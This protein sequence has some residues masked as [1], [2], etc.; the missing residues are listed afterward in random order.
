MYKVKLCVWLE[1]F[2]ASATIRINHSRSV[3]ADQSELEL[4]ELQLAIESEICGMTRDKLIEL[5]EHLEVATEGLGKLQMSKRIRETVEANVETSEDKMAFLQELKKVVCSEPPPP[6]PL[7]ISEDDGE[8]S[9]S[10]NANVEN[11]GPNVENPGPNVENPVQSKS[12][13]TETKV[14]VDLAKVFKRDFKIFG[15]I[16]GD[17]HKDSL[18]FVSLTRQ[19]DTGVKSGYK[20]TEVIE[21]VIRAVSP[22]LKL[23]SYLE[24][25]SELTL[26]RLKQILRAHFKE[27]SATELYQELAQLCQGTKESAQDF[28]IRAMNL[29]QQ[30]IFSS[31]SDSAVKYDPSLV[32]SLFIHVVETGLA[33]E[34]VRAKLRPLLEKSNV[35]DEELM[36]RVNRAVSAET[37][38]QNKMGGFIK[39]STLVN[40]VHNDP[41]PA[42]DNQ[43]I[44]GKKKPGANSDKECKQ[45]NLVAALEAV[46]ADLAS[47]KEAFNKSQASS[48]EQPRENQQV[49]NKGKSVSCKACQESGETNCSHCF[50]CGSTEH[51]ARG[52]KK[53]QGNDR[54]LCL[55]DRV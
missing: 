37:E 10:N 20:E 14:S 32:Q 38:R 55:R 42:K 1:R 27:K 33:Q 16:G 44:H 51:Y 52:C 22:S 3:M 11:P 43:N 15:T 28:L 23:R 45:N 40:Q 48:K 9:N 24:M 31:Q 21:A 47:L 30:V 39:K 8:S 25:M 29:R 13:G 26:P 18:S 19:I 34:S 54:R 35:S 53:P 49:P 17:S 36:D 12:E 46:Q 2:S 41:S 7:E 50:K 4:E 5:A 6:P